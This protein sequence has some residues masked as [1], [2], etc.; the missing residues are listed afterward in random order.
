MEWNKYPETQPEELTDYWVACNTKNGKVVCLAYYEEG[1]DWY[2]SDNT[3][4][5][6]KDEVL[7]DQGFEVYAFLSYEIPS[8]PSFD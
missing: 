7:E 1:G 4:A 8:P 2:F 3:I 5:H 6:W